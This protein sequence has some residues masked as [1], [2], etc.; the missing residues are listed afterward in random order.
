MPTTSRHQLAELL[1]SLR[2]GR[3]SRETALR[4]AS[5]AGTIEGFVN[6]ANAHGKCAELISMGVRNNLNDSSSPWVVI[7]APKV[8]ENFVR[9][10]V[11]PDPTSA[12]D[13]IYEVRISGGRHVFVAGAQVK[14][15]RPSYISR[16]L[17]AHA[18]DSRYS[19]TCDV[20]ARF[21]EVD[22]LPRVGPGA[23][24]KGQAAALRKAGFRFVGIEHL[25]QD[26]R[27]IHA[28]LVGIRERELLNR[29]QELLVATGYAPKRVAMRAGIAGG[30]TVITV[31]VGES[32]R[33]YASYRRA[34]EAGRMPNRL[35]ARK[36][37]VR[38]A[39]KSVA[40]QAAIAG[41]FV[42]AGTMVEAGAFHV[43][44]NFM[45]APKAQFTAT[46]VIAAGYA[47]LDIIAEVVEC[48]NGRISATEAVVCACIK[49]A[50]NGLS[51]VLGVVAGRVGATVGM[52]VSTGIKWG[53]QRVRKVAWSHSVASAPA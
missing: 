12:R 28:G 6:G 46:V 20:D 33:Q 23:F 51:I 11:S 45:P 14:V 8:P 16:S 27:R 2:T 13:L 15:G 38:Q 1:L 39:T 5:G 9:S 32:C 37:F 41:G 35:D 3:L 44:K 31:V 29:Q 19:K 40:T 30:A 48:R 49:T 22:G 43:A 4:L 18:S 42:A 34:V 10:Y 52:L 53:L 24:T 21:V 17:L 50:A 25:E 26:A 47:S 36:E 7:N